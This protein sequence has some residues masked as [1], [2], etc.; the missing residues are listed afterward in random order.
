MGR[1]VTQVRV[2]KEC[3]AGTSWWLN[4]EELGGHFRGW[5]WGGEYWDPLHFVYIRLGLHGLD[6]FIHSFIHSFSVFRSLLFPMENRTAE[7]LLFRGWCSDEA[8]GTR[9]VHQAP[10]KETH[11]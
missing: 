5:G 1:G 8:N 10:C 3:R 6:L 2:R 7:P 4:Q 11:C 9:R